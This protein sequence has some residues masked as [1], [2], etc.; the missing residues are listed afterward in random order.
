MIRHHKE[1]PGMPTIRTFAGALLAVGLLAAAGLYLA[2]AEKKPKYSIK[3]VM[4][5]AH[6]EG[7]LKKVASGKGDK[8]DKDKLLELYTALS[9]NKPPKGDADDW[10]DRTA[11]MVAAARDVSKGEEGAEKKLAKTVNCM[12]CHSLHRPKKDE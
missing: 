4:E 5:E 6:K 10:K 3:E 7:L 12:G 11:K 2:A 8:E 9:Q 1:K